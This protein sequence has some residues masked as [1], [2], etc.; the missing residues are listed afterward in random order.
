MESVGKMKKVLIT[1]G[2][3]FIGSQVVA[4]LLCK[5]YEVHSLVYP[6]FAPEQ[7]NLVQ[8][9]MNLMDDKAVDAFLA[10]NS[11][12]T[13]I[14]LAWYVGP[15]CQTS[16]LNIDWLEASLHL[17]KS[18]HHFGGTTALVAGS[19]SEY[20]FS[21][22]WC[23]ED[24]TPLNPLSLYGQAK[25]AL[26]ETL[27]KFC[28]F[29]DLKLKWAR[30]F[31]LYGPNEKPARLMPSVINAML[32]GEDVKV[33]PCTQTQNYLYVSDAAEAIVDFLESDVTGAVN[34]AADTA[35]RL[36]DIVEK[37]KELTGFKGNILY[38][39]IP[40][41]FN[42]QFL[43][44]DNTRL[45]KEIGWHQKTGLEDGLKQTIQWWRERNV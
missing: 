4:E 28:A 19:M 31:N 24:K 32:N 37:I 8:H 33:S 23:R 35:V 17:I 29:T 12:D 5:G 20:D 14:H 22:G 21:Y 9:E 42:Q 34:I 45:T 16:A 7:P 43:S 27:K 36:R 11:F 44:G 41:A 15:K 30:L 3:G 10:E 38:G 25:A 40:P 2:T 26:Y 6:P 39:A 13:L 1:G 18:F